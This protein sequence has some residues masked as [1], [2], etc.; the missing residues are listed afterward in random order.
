MTKRKP[1]TG[2][3][4][5]KR[6]FDV[7]LGPASP[8]KAIQK[9]PQSR[10]R[11]EESQIQRLYIQAMLGPITRAG[12]ATGG[13]FSIRYPQLRLLYSTPNAGRRSFVQGGIMKAEGM[14]KGVPD[15]CLPVARGNWH[16]LYLEFKTPDGKLSGEQYDVAT[17]LLAEHNLVLVVRDLQVA[18]DVTLAYLNK[19]L[20]T[21]AQLINRYSL[22]PIAP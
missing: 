7:L 21:L 6:A 17:S 14:L 9:R 5:L 1:P 4:E 22:F 20:D 10:P 8:L 19:D 2:S 18:I 16:A 3:P 12:R 13:G 15:L 11:H